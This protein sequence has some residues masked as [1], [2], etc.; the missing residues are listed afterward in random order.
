MWLRHVEVRDLYE[1]RADRQDG[2]HGL[3]GRVDLALAVANDLAVDDRDEEVVGVAVGASRG[4][5]PSG[6]RCTCSAELQRRSIPI[7]EDLDMG[8]VVLL[9]GPSSAGKTSIG[10]A[11]RRVAPRPTVFLDGDEMDLPQ[12]SAARQWLATLDWQEVAALEDQF[13]GGFYEALAAL[14][15][16]G[17]IAV[18]EVVLKKQLHLDSFETATRDVRSHV[19]RVT[20]PEHLRIEREAARGDRPIGTA[21]QTGTLEW[22]PPHITVAVDTSVLDADAAAQVICQ[23][24]NL[25]T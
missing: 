3:I 7:G 11:L 18:G 8:A 1:R 15:R 10:Q 9:T 22:V 16:A 19:V 13:F 17:L 20:C 4:R 21:E 14:A 2:G 12:G 24:I 6:R 25:T 5:A 23:A